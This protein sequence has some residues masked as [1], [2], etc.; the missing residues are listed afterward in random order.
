MSTNLERIKQFFG[1]QDLTRSVRPLVAMLLF[2]IP[3]IITTFLSNGMTL[4]NSLVLKETVGGDSVTAI[5]QTNALSA[6]ILQFGYGCTSGFGIVV[7]NFHGAKDIEKT[8]K[9]IVSSIIFCF[10]IWLVIAPLGIIFLKVMLHALNV[11]EL[12]FDRA[13]NYF[14]IIL[15]FYIF[16]LLSNLSGHILRALGN[17]FT[18]LVSS[19]LT[20]LNH[21]G[22]VYL[23]TAKYLGNLDTRGAAIATIITSI[24]NLS[25]CFY[26]VFRKYKIG[27]ESFKFD[28]SIYKDLAKLGVPLGF[29]WSVLYIGS[30]VL[31]RQVNSFGIYASKGMA[32]YSSWETLAINSIMGAIGTTVVN[33]TGQ[34]YGAKKY[35]RVKKG[36]IDGYILVAIIYSVMLVALLPTVKLVPYIYLPKDEINERVI[37]YSTT[38]LYITISAAVFQG[39]INVSRGALQGIKRPLFPF[40]SG[41]GELAGRIGVSLLVPFIIDA[42]YKT[43]LSDKSYVG[44]SF[45]NATAWFLSAL[46]MGIA[47]LILILRNKKFQSDEVEEIKKDI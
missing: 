15:I 24:L 20:S 39:I 5:N 44:L 12:Y 10:A 47:V 25:I 8:K 2:A 33:F 32:I 38:Y 9:A 14:L 45:S 31:A 37:F 26:F 35:M 27:K 29:Q 16:S 36:I 18:V 6:L 40:I 4:I 43:T 42:N 19:I 11:D 23:L 1:Y 30:F 17:S 7:A 3:L 22:F 41:L 34:N 46:I 13:Y 28:K 21:I